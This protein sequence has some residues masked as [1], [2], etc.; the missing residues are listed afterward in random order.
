MFK[1]RFYLRFNPSKRTKN[2]A[3]P[4]GLGRKLQNL[5]SMHMANRKREFRKCFCHYPDFAF[6][7]VI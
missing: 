4:E 1:A 2:E 6:G 7:N 5:D 3:G